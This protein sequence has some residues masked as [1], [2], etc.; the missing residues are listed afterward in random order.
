VVYRLLSSE[1]RLRSMK[2][3]CFWCQCVPCRESALYQT[4]GVLMNLN[5]DLHIQVVQCSIC[6][7]WQQYLWSS[8]ERLIRP[9]HKFY[10]LRI[11]IPA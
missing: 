1:E 11:G 9:A 7:R 3:V 10:M 6:R 8:D 4:V 5:A 2:S